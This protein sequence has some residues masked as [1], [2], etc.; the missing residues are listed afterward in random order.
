MNIKQIYNINEIIPLHQIIFGEEF[1]LQ[2]FC[3]KKRNND[4]LIFVYEE[5]GSNIGYSIAILQ[6]EER[7]IYAWYGGIIPKYQ[8]MGITK[9]WFENLFE[10]AKN[11]NFQTIT[12]ATSNLRPHMITFAVK[13]GFDIY[14]LKKRETGEG[15]KIYFKYTIRPESSAVI[16]LD[17]NIRIVDLEKKL[18]EL[19]K[20]NTTTLVIKDIYSIESLMYVVKYC[21]SFIRK[22]KLIITKDKKIFDK[23]LLQFIREYK[24]EIKFQS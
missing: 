17:M 24:G 11:N 12:V 13:M 18:V 14:N 3:K 21:N 2:S 7:N 22:P 20:H 8:G 1:P 15:N 5:N 19:Y 9:R 4:V 16:S 6:T 23:L 10:Y